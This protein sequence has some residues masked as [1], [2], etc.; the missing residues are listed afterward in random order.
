MSAFFGR[1]IKDSDYGARGDKGCLLSQHP[2]FHGLVTRLHT[3]W[4]HPRAEYGYKL[5]DGSKVIT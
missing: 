3:E 4:V 5:F 2:R 1:G